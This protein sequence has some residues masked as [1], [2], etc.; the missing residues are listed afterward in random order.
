MKAFGFTLISLL[1]LPVL[2][3]SQS[4]TIDQHRISGGGGTS[5][6][7]EF[8][9]SGTIGQPEAGPLLSGGNFS[10]AGGFWSVY[11]AVQTSGAPVLA[12]V[13]SGNIVE[14]RWAMENA[15]GLTLEEATVLGTTADW[16]PI[17]TPPALVDGQYT[18]TLTVQPGHHFF[19]LRQP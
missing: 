19:R 11:V 16:N 15:T 10:V 17:N 2:L 18:L 9:L 6:G 7:G 14:S 3:K 13:R 1:C 8:T 4:L 5:S 12:I